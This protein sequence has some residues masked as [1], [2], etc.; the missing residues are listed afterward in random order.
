M[1]KCANMCRCPLR[2]IFGLLTFII[3]CLGFAVNNKAQIS[4]FIAS[5]FGK[6]AAKAFENTAAFGASLTNAVGATAAKK[7]ANATAA[8]SAAVKSAA[9]S[10]TAAA[11]G[12]SANATSATS[13]TV[14]AK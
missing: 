12:A 2:T 6:D 10:A 1:P 4:G 8:A 11:A 9:A 5:N 7:A 13:S 3:V 14:V